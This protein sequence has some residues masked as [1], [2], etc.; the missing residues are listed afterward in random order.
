MTLRDYQEDIIN[1]TISTKK[2]TLIQVPT[3]GGKTVIAYHIAM[4]LIVKHNQQ[5]LFVVPQENLM[6]QTYA[7][8]KNSSP[9][10]I[11]SSN[12]EDKKIK[13]YSFKEYPLLISTIQTAYK[14]ININPDVIIIDEVHFGF[15][16]IMINMLIR[17]KNVRVIGLSATPYDKNGRQLIGFDVIIDK[18]DIRY[19]IDNKY[20]VPLKTYK[21]T[22]V[23]LKS[24][25]TNQY[26]D[27]NEKD[28]DKV[29]CNNTTIMEIVSTT[30]E[31]V[32]NSFKTIVFAVSTQHA[33]LLSQAYK[34]VGFSSKSIHFKSEEKDAEVIEEF[35]RGYIKVLV[36]VSKLTTGFDVPETDTAIIARPTKSQN[37][38]KQMVGRVLRLSENTDKTHAILLDCANVIDTVGDP[39]AP[40]K[41][42]ENKFE[43][44]EMRCKHCNSL[45]FKM[46]SNNNQKFWECK[47]CGFKKEIKNGTYKCKFCG[48]YSND[49]SKFI[50][51]ESSILLDCTSCGLKSVISQ[52]NNDNEVLVN[53]EDNPYK[54]TPRLDE[55]LTWTYKAI[56]V[57]YFGEEIVNDNNVKRKIKNLLKLSYREKQNLELDI[58]DGVF[59][60]KVKDDNKMLFK[61]RNLKYYLHSLEN[62]ELLSLI[63]SVADIE[64]LIPLEILKNKL[65]V[66][67]VLNSEF[68][69][70]ILLQNKIRDK[71]KFSY[72]FLFL[73]FIVAKT[74]GYKSIVEKFKDLVSK[75]L[76]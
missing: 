58:I 57:D 15:D 11:H 71:S 50:F 34:N 27:F 48:T 2:S 60:Q 4:E 6:H 67:Y 62:H 19:M 37:L 12:N 59:H 32:E 76:E 72:F 51:F 24:V 39:L 56:L 31:F 33:D 22:K 8:F 68:E 70:D 61:K 7:Q 20:L 75:E 18:Y 46:K 47:D 63:D 49:N 52:V 9:H 14:R 25:K 66:L 16:G 21:R 5:I 64:E 17:N 74:N 1:K 36:S 26:G 45:N 35:K 73:T 42:A 13:E 30:K 69:D 44:S 55:E 54:E 28:L 29:V 43:N 40:I 53:T 65:T 10:V 41:I 3:G 23:N 38:Y